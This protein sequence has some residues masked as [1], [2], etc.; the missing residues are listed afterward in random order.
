M[1]SLGDTILAASVGPA[2]VGNCGRGSGAFTDA[3]GY[4]EKFKKTFPP[5]YAVNKIYLKNITLNWSTY[6]AFFVYD[7]SNN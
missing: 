1:C 6:A 3:M 2:T 4:T 7:A 5:M